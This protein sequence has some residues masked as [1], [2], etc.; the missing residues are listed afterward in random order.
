MLANFEVL[1]PATDIPSRFPRSLGA[2]AMTLVIQ[3]GPF[4]VE[5]SVAGF[6]AL[7]AS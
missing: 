2:G 5:N 7:G 3:R 6:A 1:A 4:L